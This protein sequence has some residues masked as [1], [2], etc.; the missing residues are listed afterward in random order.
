MTVQVSDFH[1]AEKKNTLLFFCVKLHVMPQKKRR[2][3]P[4]N[5]K[6]R[7]QMLQWVA[8]WASIRLNSRISCFKGAFLLSTITQM[9]FR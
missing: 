7:K 4:S 6:T 1:T 9:F 3:A 2:T 5:E 8:A